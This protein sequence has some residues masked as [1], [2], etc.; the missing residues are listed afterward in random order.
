MGATGSALG[1][2]QDSSIRVYR[3]IKPAAEGVIKVSVRFTGAAV[4][5]VQEKVK[6]KL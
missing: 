6:A 4:A 5:Q 3:E 1:R 2:I